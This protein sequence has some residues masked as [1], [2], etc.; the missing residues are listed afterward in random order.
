MGEACWPIFSSFLPTIRPGVS[1]STKNRLMPL[2]FGALWS[3][4]AHT[5]N[6]SAKEPLVMN[7]LVPFRTQSS[8][9]RTAVVVIPAGS[10]PAPGSVRPKAPAGYSPLQIFSMY[11]FFCSSVPRA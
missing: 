9:S 1:A 6:T 4:T 7:N 8:P 11:F 10:E 3:V 2:P 5:T